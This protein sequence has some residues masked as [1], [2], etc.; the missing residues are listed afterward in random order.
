MEQIMG[1][2]NSLASAID[3]ALFDTFVDGMILGFLLFLGAYIIHNNEIFLT[4]FNYKNTA[5]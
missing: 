3:A 1:S 5:K 4:I 2:N